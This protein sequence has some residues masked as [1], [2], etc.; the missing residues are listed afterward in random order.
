MTSQL[1]FFVIIFFLFLLQLS[2]S[3]FS[4]LLHSQ[5]LK[6]STFLFLNCHFS[7]D[8]FFLHCFAIVVMHKF[9]LLDSSPTFLLCSPTLF[10]LYLRILRSERL[11][12]LLLV[13]FVILHF[14]LNVLL[15]PDNFLQ[16]SLFGKESLLFLFQFH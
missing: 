3:K 14:P 15:I 1:Q 8:L 5:F 16:F 6:R 12:E 7:A 11:F 13:G 9:F 4:L 2:F 10:L